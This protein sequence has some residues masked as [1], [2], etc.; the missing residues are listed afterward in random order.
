MSELEIAD[1][2]TILNNNNNNKIK[3]QQIINSKKIISTTKK[4]P[5]ISDEKKKIIETQNSS[6][7]DSRSRSAP[8]KKSK[9]TTDTENTMKPV[10]KIP[11]ISYEIL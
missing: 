2:E 11:K 4:P 8:V 5:I 10:I 6:L 9:S 7:I 3:K 1:N